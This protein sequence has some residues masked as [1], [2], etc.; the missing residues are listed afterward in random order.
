MQIFIHS[1][2][3]NS[4]RW[5]IDATP[6]DTVASLKERMADIHGDAYVAARDLVYS[7]IVLEDLSTLGE[8]D[9]RDADDIHLVPSKTSLTSDAGHTHRKRRSHRRK[10]RSHRRKRRSHRRKRRSHGRKRRSH[11]RKRRSHRRRS[12]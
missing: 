2:G 7:G 4:G 6:G 12:H 3:E 11:G 10:R 5:D 8:Y 9:I 1:Y